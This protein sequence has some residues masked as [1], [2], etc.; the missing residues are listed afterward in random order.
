MDANGQVISRHN[1]VLPCRWGTRMLRLEWW[2]GGSEFNPGNFWFQK[3]ST[4]K[5][6]IMKDTYILRNVDANKIT[7]TITIKILTVDG[8]DVETA[9]MDGYIKIST[10]R[11]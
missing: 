7:D 1:G 4:V 8:I 6:E 2:D 3:N 9:V 5:P 10:G 11:L